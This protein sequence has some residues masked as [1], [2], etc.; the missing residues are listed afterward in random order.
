MAANISAAAITVTADNKSKVYGAANPALTA[1]YSGFVNGENASVLSGSPSLSTTVNASSTVDG[2]P[3]PITAAAG[4]LSAANYSFSFV[5]GT[6][7]VG[8][9]T[10]TVTADDASR[11]YGET[12]PVFTASYSGFVN[13]DDTNVL[14]GAAELSTVADTNS[15]V[16]GSPYT[17]TATNGTL[18]ATNY[19]FEFVEGQLTIAQAMLTVKADNQ[20]ME[21]GAAVPP[22]TVSYLGFVNGEDTSV[23]SGSPDLSTPVTSE[24]EPGVYPI[25]VAV[26]SLSAANYSLAFASGEFTVTAVQTSA[27][28]QVLVSAKVAL[29]VAPPATLTGIQVVP[30]GMKITFTGSA[31]FTYQ[32]Q[33]AAALQS[34]QTVWENVGSAT[35]D[36][37]GHGEFT[38]TN[39]PSGQGYYRTVSP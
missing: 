4:T 17:I 35:A 19:Q 11:A 29:F 22:L 6:L 9:A 13:S 21:Y 33:R 3:Y 16:G 34:S 23:L 31:G 14:S 18:S 8:K 20:T 15:P 1:S 5:N 30:T 25:T 32:I 36:D 28:P 10:L 27:A 2:S 24:T 39:P 37:A 12:N 26:G 7:T 38:D